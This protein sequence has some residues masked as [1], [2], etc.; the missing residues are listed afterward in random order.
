MLCVVEDAHWLDPATADALLFCAR[1]LGA[2]R[3]LLVFSARDAT[4]TSFRAEGIDE[5]PLSGLDPD[6]A[7][8]LLG[9]RLGTA[10]APEVAGRLIVETG[11]NPLALL[12]FPAE[13]S[14]AQL[15]GSAPLPTQLHLS[16]RVEQAFLDRS[17]RLPAPSQSLLLL[18]AADDTG[19]LA[20]VRAAASALGVDEQALE[21]AV[22]SGCSSRTP[23][24][25]RCATR[26]C[27]PRSI[28]PPPGRND[29][30]R[31]G[32]WPTPWR[33]AGTPTAR[34]GT[35]PPLPRAPTHTSSPASSSSG[36]TPSVVVRTSR[37]W[38][39]TNARQR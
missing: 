27:A 38:T 10:P 17:R 30:G 32:P 20:V 4:A 21:A 9:Q 3:L 26:W 12:E 2:D 7:R 1:R 18:A 34:R 14:A 6:A 29:D 25:F 8:A 22:A 37:P 35:A 13:L 39:P 19:E 16:T 5:L 23:R 31:T 11:G 15:G 28:K 36:P 24:A 33:V